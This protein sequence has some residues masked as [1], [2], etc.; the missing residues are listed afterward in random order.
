[1]IVYLI[2]YMGSGKS[3]I[4]KK[5][6]ASL[7]WSFIDLDKAIEEEIKLSISEIFKVRGEAY[8]RELESDVL[9]KFKSHKNTI[10]SCG[11]GTP[12]YHDNMEYMNDTGITVYIRMTPAALRSRLKV[13]KSNRPLIAD[14]NDD[15]L[16]SYIQESLS[17][18]EK[19]Y[20]K[21]KLEIEGL[22]PNTTQLYE[23]LRD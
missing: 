11:G 1:M 10:I 4:A 16:L 12:C 3:T 20:T 8:F 19:W 5:I 9:R 18:R 7:A 21:A 23:I 17:L 22:N 2:G 13:N 6:A 15:E 14:K